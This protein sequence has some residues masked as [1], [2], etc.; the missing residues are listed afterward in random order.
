MNLLLSVDGQFWRTPD[1]KVWSKTMYSY[2]FWKRY[3]NVFDYVD[4]VSRIKDIEYEKVPGY[5]RC[6]G[7]R[8]TFKEFPM[9]IG[10][11]EYLAQWR[12][13]RKCANKATQ[14]NQCAII[15]LPSISG[16]VVENEYRKTGKPYAVEVVVDPMTAYADNRLF[17]LLLTGLLKR[18]VMSANGV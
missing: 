9:A 1:G 4:I 15:R 11:K 12:Q 17:Q 7:E 3:L 13:I 18:S 16:F 2:E 10:A 5:L 8:V 6:D 14:G